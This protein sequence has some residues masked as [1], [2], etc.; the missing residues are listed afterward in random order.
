MVTWNVWRRMSNVEGSNPVQFLYYG[1][2]D[3]LSADTK[4]TNN[5]FNGSVL[6]EIDT[7]NIYKFDQSSNSWMLTW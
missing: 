3:C 6:T 2:G 5:I 7:G 4:P 1:E